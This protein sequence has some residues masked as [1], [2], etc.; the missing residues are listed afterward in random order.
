MTIDS[1]PATQTTIGATIDATETTD[2]PTQAATLSSESNMD[3]RDPTIKEVIPGQTNQPDDISSHTHSELPLQVPIQ[4]QTSNIDTRGVDAQ[5]QTPESQC[6]LDDEGFVEMFDQLRRTSIDP[7]QVASS[8]SA[9]PQASTIPVDDPSMLRNGCLKH[10]KSAQGFKDFSVMLNN[11]HRA[12][13][14]SYPKCI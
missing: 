3:N 10:F 13:F 7:G 1:A 2:N 8:S 6:L 9:T 5:C 12:G 14:K 4:E 11:Q